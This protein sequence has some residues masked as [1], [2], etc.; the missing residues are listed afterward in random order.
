M[1]TSAWKNGNHLINMNQVSMSFYLKKKGWSS[2]EEITLKTVAEKL[3]TSIH[4]DKF[5]N[6]IADFKILYGD[7]VK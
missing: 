5:N 3:T 1:K 7:I 2:N 4:F 6:S